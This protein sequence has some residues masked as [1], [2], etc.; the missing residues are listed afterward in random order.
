KCEGIA[1]HPDNIRSIPACL[2]EQ[3]Q[4]EVGSDDHAGTAGLPGSGSNYAGAAGHVQH[5]IARLNGRDG[6]M[7]ASPRSEPGRLEVLRVYDGRI[8]SGSWPRCG[9]EFAHESI[10]R[11]GQSGD[12]QLMMGLRA[13]GDVEVHR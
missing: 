11:Q 5:A 4:A 7:L 13:S 2:A 9:L 6:H 1:L 8:I 10:I 3:S 12:P